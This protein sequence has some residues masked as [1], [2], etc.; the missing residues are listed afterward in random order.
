MCHP[1]ISSNHCIVLSKEKKLFQ[2]EATEEPTEEVAE[3]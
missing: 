1:Y 3:E 2:A